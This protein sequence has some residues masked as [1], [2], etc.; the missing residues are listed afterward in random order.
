[1]TYPYGF[2]FQYVSI[3]IYVKQPLLLTLP[4]YIPI[5]FYFNLE[6]DSEYSRGGDIYIP[7]CFYFNAYAD[8]ITTETTQFTFQYVSI[9]ISMEGSK[10]H[11]RNKFTFQYVSILMLIQIF[12]FFFFL[13]IYIPI[14]FYFNTLAVLSFSPSRAIYIPICFYFNVQ[15]IFS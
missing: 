4:I 14:C 13:S 10:E 15:T 6:G 12:S 2:T 1:M 8:Y 9:L 11:G 5:C 7:I 3:L